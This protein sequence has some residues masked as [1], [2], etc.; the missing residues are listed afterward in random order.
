MANAWPGPELRR[1]P[2]TNEQFNEQAC[3][4]AAYP[5]VSA[6]LPQLA[7]LQVRMQL[8]LHDCRAHPEVGRGEQRL[9]P[10]WADV[11]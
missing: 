3:S 7:H 11:R 4:S 5:M 1:R 9:E 10:I 8:R 6:A 2:V